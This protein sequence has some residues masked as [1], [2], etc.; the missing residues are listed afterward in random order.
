[1]EYKTLGGKRTRILNYFFYVLIIV[2][3]KKFT[4]VRKW[5]HT[6]LLTHAGEKLSCNA[7]GVQ[8]QPEL[9]EPIVVCSICD[10]DFTTIKCLAIH[11]KKKHRS[12]NCRTW[13]GTFKKSKSSQCVTI[14]TVTFLG[15]RSK[16]WNTIWG[17][18]EQ[19][20]HYTRYTQPNPSVGG[21]GAEMRLRSCVC[22]ILSLREVW[23]PNVELL[24]MRVRSSQKMPFDKT[25]NLRY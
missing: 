3:E 20:N 21:G 18:E 11:V 14:I 15:T 19:C 17:T 7:T 13:D 4:I 1:M 23:E 2:Q 5:P 12:H 22:C 16:A 24:T 8:G 25:F 10:K 9:M 6:R